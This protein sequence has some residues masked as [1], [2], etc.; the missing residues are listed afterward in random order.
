MKFNYH[1]IVI[2]AGSGGLV[3]ASGAAGLGARVALIEADKMGGDCLN[4]GCVPSKSFLKS[5]HFAADIQRSEQLGINAQH[6]DVDLKTVMARVHSV[7]K[8]IEPHD[9]KERFESLG[10]DVIS[11]RGR[12]LDA[13]S[14]DIGGRVITGKNLVIATGSRAAV[15][16]IPGLNEIPFLTNENIFDLEVLPR[17]LLVLGAGPI[18]L[19][20]GQGFC[21][22][23]SQVTIVDKASYLFL[24][25]DPEVAPIMEKKLKDDGVDLRLNSSIQSVREEGDEIVVTIEFKRRKQELR[26][27]KLLVALGRKP[28]S[29]GLGLEDVGVETDPGGSISVNRK[30]QTSV[31]N[32]YACGDVTGPYQ[33]THMAGYQAGIVI[34]NTIFRLGTKVDYSAVPWTTYTRPEVAHVGYT[35]PWAKSQGLFHDSVVIPLDGIDRAKAEGDTEGFLKLIL[36]KKNRLVGITLVGEKAGEMIPVGTLAIRQKLKATAFMSLIF[37]YP[38]ESE[39]FKMAALEL[40]KRALKDWVKRVIKWIFLR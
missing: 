19:E 8:S 26:G 6:K 5:A 35:E 34:R 28:S 22:L 2:G 36:G 18:G 20:L 3:V 38:T 1:V 40:A 27:D 31:K 15:P 23:G 30:L 14:V 4:T 10:V 7:I 12:L 37:S 32:I 16:P 21:H 33:F 11:G 25:D 13:H 9:S 39:I 24:K 17:R 29:S